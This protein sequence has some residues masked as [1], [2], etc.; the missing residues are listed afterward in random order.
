MKI[1]NLILFAILVLLPTVNLTAQ[2]ISKG[3]AQAIP[4]SQLQISDQMTTN[5]IFPHAIKSVDR[6]N[7][8]ILVQKANAVENILQVKAESSEMH[9]SNLTVITA[10]GSFYS[11]AV[12]Y[13][14]V[15]QNLNLKIQHAAKA[16]LADFSKPMQTESELA[17]NARK[18][19]RKNRSIPPIR[20]RRYLTGIALTG[21]YIE[22]DLLYFQ[23]RLENQTNIPYDIEQFRLFIRDNKQSKRSASQELEQI[24][25]LIYGE[26]DRIPAQSTQ[27]LVV[28]LPKFT[29]P[30]QKQ[31]KIELMEQKGG[32]H[33]QIKVKNRH[34]MKAMHVD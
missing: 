21:I 10:D 2:G 7:R 5:L 18:V 27:T 22:N 19:A 9:N 17:E 14:E 11:F 3:S 33:L 16:E 31:L 29:I 34:L 8:K 12:E 28:A 1:I 24:P 13:Q 4:A 30:D 23:L 20:Q 32:R 6:G 25:L 15:P 26:S